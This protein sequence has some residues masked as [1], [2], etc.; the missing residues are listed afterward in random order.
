MATDL[1]RQFDGAMM[2]IYQRAKTEAKYN[3]NVFL[4]M[5][6][7]RGGLATARYLI[8]SASASEGYTNL[9]ERN[10]LD[11]TVEALV[12]E[13]GKW[14]PLFTAEELAK[15]KARLIAYNYKF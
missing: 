5:L 15:A 1:E 8:N 11:L 9:W 13:N 4:G 6:S 10:R 12:L 2:A 14:H 7:D 3:A